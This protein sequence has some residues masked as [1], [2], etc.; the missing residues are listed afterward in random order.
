MHRGAGSHP[1]R[2]FRR[3]LPHDAGDADDLLL[4][5]QGLFLA[6]GRGLVLQL[7]VPPFDQAVGLLLGEGGLVHGLAGDEEVLAVLEVAD[8][9]LAPEPF[10]QEDVGDRRGQGAVGTRLE[11]KPLLGLGGRGGKTRVHADDRAALEDV[12]ELVDGVGNLA[13]GA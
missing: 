1:D 3:G 7:D 8:E 5:N 12:A 9:L 10:R 13:V 4:G 11:G 2:R 6:P